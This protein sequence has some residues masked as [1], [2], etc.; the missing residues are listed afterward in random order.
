MRDSAGMARP[1]WTARSACGFVRRST[2]LKSMFRR[3]TG[4]SPKKKG[5][6]FFK[7]GP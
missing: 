3:R 6:G 4:W 1:P 2:E 7:P 5:P